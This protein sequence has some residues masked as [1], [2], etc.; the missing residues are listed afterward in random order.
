M[1]KL[2]HFNSLLLLWT[3]FSGY[4]SEPFLKSVYSSTFLSSATWRGSRNLPSCVNSAPLNNGCRLLTNQ[5]HNHRTPLTY[6]AWHLLFHPTTTV[7]RV[8]EELTH[9]FE[10]RGTSICIKKFLSCICLHRGDKCLDRDIARIMTRKR[11]FCKRQII[12]GGKEAKWPSVI[13]EPTEGTCSPIIPSVA[14]RWNGCWWGGR[15][16]VPLETKKEPC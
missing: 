10:T 1:P 3:F 5:D 11:G 6:S 7:V 14:R 9:I 8:D 13:A 15:E 16:L 4:Q 2:N 12:M